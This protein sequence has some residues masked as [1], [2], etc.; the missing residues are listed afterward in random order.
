VTLENQKINVNQNSEREVYHLI[1]PEKYHNQDSKNLLIEEQKT[2]DNKTIRIYASGL[3]EVYFPSGVRR[4][5][6]SDGY[7]VIFF[8]NKDIRQQYANGK[9]VYYFSDHQITQTLTERGDKI[10]LFPNG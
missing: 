4:E 1:F 5:S 2:S 7:M 3:K 8:E 10:L 6:Y 9:M